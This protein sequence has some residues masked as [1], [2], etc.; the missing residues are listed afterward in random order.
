[1][2]NVKAADRTGIFNL[3][4]CAVSPVL[5]MWVTPPAPSCH[6]GCPYLARTSGCSDTGCSTPLRCPRRRS[7]GSGTALWVGLRGAGRSSGINYTGDAV[8]RCDEHPAAAQCSAPLRTRSDSLL[9][10]LQPSPRLPDISPW[11]VSEKHEQYLRVPPPASVCTHRDPLLLFLGPNK[12]A[13]VWYPIP[14]TN[15]TSP[16]Y[17]RLPVHAE[18]PCAPGRTW[19]P[20]HPQVA[21][22][23]PSRRSPSALQPL[24][25]GPEP[26][27]CVSPTAAHVCEAFL[28]FCHTDRP[29]LPHLVCLHRSRWLNGFSR[30][31]VQDLSVSTWTYDNLDS[32]GCVVSVPSGSREMPHRFRLVAQDLGIVHGAHNMRSRWSPFYGFP[33]A[34]ESNIHSCVA[35]N[36]TERQK[37][38]PQSLFSD[39]LTP[40]QLSQNFFNSLTQ[41]LT[42]QP[43]GRPAN[44]LQTIV[45]PLKEQCLFTLTQQQRVHPTAQIQELIFQSSSFSFGDPAIL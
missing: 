20:G 32:F 1:M 43:C 5:L 12:G 13:E 45:W 29:V 17:C 18:S 25:W 4:S 38:A 35:L 10:Y 9:W 27:Q 36:I 3:L 15:N 8:E 24:R 42:N 39:L 40:T 22:L 23:P 19:L 31:A 7:S 16:T 6:C 34:L 33:A 21:P 41:P 2:L 44:N 28:S 14:Q 37:R 30:V 11:V 26:G